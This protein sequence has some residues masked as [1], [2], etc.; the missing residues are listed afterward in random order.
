MSKATYIIICDS[1]VGIA[2]ADS[3]LSPNL[4]EK[5]SSASAA[6]R[7]LAMFMGDSLTEA[8]ANRLSAILHWFEDEANSHKDQVP[9]KVTELIELC[10]E[11]GGVTG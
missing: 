2:L 9:A 7:N 5:V 11:I 6:A 10:E 3:S 4:K 1:E 8:D